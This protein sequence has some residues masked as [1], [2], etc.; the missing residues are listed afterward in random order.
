MNVLIES[1]THLGMGRG[2]DGQLYPRVLPDETIEVDDG[3]YRILTPSKYRVA[4]PCSHFKSCGGCAMQ[5]AA[6]PF[7]ENWKQTIVERALS[8]KGLKPPFR[9]IHTSP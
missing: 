6:D 4:A 3:D 2:S 7:V 9:P 8:A 1:L 5:H